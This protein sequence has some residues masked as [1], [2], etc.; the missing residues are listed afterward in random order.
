MED[1]G[2]RI[3][4]G[5]IY[6][7][8][9]AVRLRYR[10]PAERRPGRRE[11]MGRTEA[12]ASAVILCLLASLALYLVSPPWMAWSQ[13]ALH[14]SLR[15]VGALLALVMIM[16]LCWIHESL[17]RFYSARL[18]TRDGHQ[19]VT[20]GPYRRV[21]HPMYSVLYVFSVSIGVLSANVLLLAFSTV[22]IYPLRL[23]AIRE[24][25]MMVRLFGEEYLRYMERTGR[26]L[27]RL[28]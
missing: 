21:R 7:V 22:L 3:L 16:L 28:G 12:L 5:L 11:A 20:Q 27:P 10:I 13:L 15:F 4:V 25:E 1:P 14:D 2:F 19:L 26:L 9:A 17:G 18:E 8:L 24:E 23:I 6:G